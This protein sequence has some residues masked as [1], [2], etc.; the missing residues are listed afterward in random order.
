MNMRRLWT[1]GLVLASGA[2]T[3]LAAD[4]S[5][6]T[7]AQQAELMADAA[8]RTSAAPSGG[9]FNISDGSGNYNLN[10]GGWTQFR[11][12]MN[13]RD[14]PES[15]DAHD[16]GFTSGFEVTRTRL[17]LSGNVI[18]P[19][20]KFKIEGEFERNDG[21]FVLK[22]AWGSY[23]FGNGLTLKWGQFKPGLLR[24]DLVGDT[25]GLAVDRSVMHGVFRQDRSQ[26]LELSYRGDS[27][28]ATFGFNDGLRTPNTPYTSP[29]EADYAF[30]GRLEFKWAGD[31]KQF[32][33]MTSFRGSEHAGMIGLAGHY[34]HSGNTAAMAGGVPVAVPQASLFE[35]TVDASFEANGWNLYGAFVG[36]HTE[37]DQGDGLDDFGFVAQG[38]LFVTD[39]LEP[40]VRYDVVFPDDERGSGN[41]E[42]FHTITVGA[43]YYISPESHAAKFSADVQLFLEAP[44]E[45]GLVRPIAN[46]GA[47][48]LQPSSEDTQFAIRLQFQLM[49]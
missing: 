46:G 28:G 10:I 37:P 24:E 29:A 23:K 22:D 32:D 45:N 12:V 39:Q 4:P 6:L 19:D 33:D 35:Y 11:Y 3:A 18:N 17:Q 25:K 21:P 41:D 31:W 20:L 8:A 36:R 34:Q 43:N 5:D 7:R 47:L 2:A 14:D 44:S 13:W 42:D 49:F 26:G 9:W 15:T 48:A 40:F 1:M 30:T 27:F 38:G 16:S